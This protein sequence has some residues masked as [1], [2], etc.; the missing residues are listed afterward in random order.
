M[1]VSSPVNPTEKRSQK[2]RRINRDLT[3]NHSVVQARENSIG[4]GLSY[5]YLSATTFVASGGIFYIIVAKLLPT[6]ALGAISLLLAI[7]SLMNIAFSFGFPISAQH[8][9][10]FNLGIGDHAETRSVARKIL[11]ISSILSSVSLIFSLVTARWVAILFFHAPYDTLL[12]EAASFYIAIGVFF[13]V[14][15]GSALGFQM[16]RTDAIIYLSSASF[17]YLLGLLL[18]LLFHGIIYLII[19]MTICYLYGTVL[20]LIYIFFKGPKVTRQSNKTSLPVILSY[21]WPILLSGLI[22]YGSTYVDRFVV[23]Y[24]LNLSTLGIYSFILLVSSSLSFLGGPIANVLVPKLSEYFSIDDN[25]KLKKGINLSSTVMMLVYSPLAFGLAS[26]APVALLLLARP[27]YATGNVALM[28]LLVTSSI[29]VLGGI[30]GSVI[31]AV[32]KTGVYVITTALTLVSNL[33]LSFLLIPRYGM[34]GAAIANS[35]VSVVTFIILYNYAVRV[36]L[37]NFDWNT[38]LKVWFS[39]LIMFVLVTAERLALGNFLHLLPLYV[40][41]GVLYYWIAINVTRSLHRL[42]REEFLSYIPSRFSLRK[43]V[44]LFLIKAF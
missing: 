17:S 34:I 14:L 6:S 37:K 24:F 29:F 18:L 4:W 30:M 27:V 3:M 12:I 44:G 26:I 25:E 39:S 15:H 33:T 13:G 31:Y 35:S 43:L 38:I 7:A 40:V 11:M 8:F 10:S 5:Q 19:G 32:R 22:G 28:I 20:Y 23:A 42:R 21:S 2:Q 1:R 36:R 41:T 16:F 9:I